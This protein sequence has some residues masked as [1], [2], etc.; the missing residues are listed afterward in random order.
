MSMTET[1]SM[2]SR[3]L[4]HGWS[5]SLLLHLGLVLAAVTLMP[6]MTIVLEQKPF[7]WEVAL[8]ESPEDSLQEETPAPVPVA[9][10]PEVAKPTHAKPAR[11]VESE[12]VVPRV[13]PQQSA[14]VVHPVI[15]PPKPQPVQ[16][17]QEIAQTPTKE[18][19]RHGIRKAEVKEPE[20]VAKQPVKQETVQE[21]VRE[22]AS[23]IEP[24]APTYTQSVP[25]MPPSEAP[26]MSHQESVAV[27]SAPPAHAAES[28]PAHVPSPSVDA[29]HKASEDVPSPVTAP[30]PTAAPSDAPAQVAK[31]APQSLPPALDAKADH[32]WVGESLWRRVAELKRYPSSA[33][34]NGLEGRVVLKAIIRADG[35]LAEVSVVK[36][37]G[38]AVLDAAAMEAVKLACPLHMKHSIGPP[39]IVVSL[40]IV[41][42][43]AN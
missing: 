41:Y 21:P 40:P 33:R 39:Q 3:H 18:P 14:Q 34:L 19:E 5:L 38:H 12:T 43:L 32:R 31:V 24:A 17:V 42:S 10:K 13:A 7:T 27:A 35:H 29:A 11:S 25:A 37:S 9:P 36:S 28:A 8:I 4:L 2:S 26:T 30:S 6:K 22:V 23:A 15:E 16:P 1:D 20:P